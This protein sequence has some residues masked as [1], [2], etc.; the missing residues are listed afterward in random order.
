MV[1]K[2]VNQSELDRSSVA[3]SLRA[4]A[5]EFESGED[6]HVRVGNK[7]IRLQPPETVSYE[8]SV[9]E[10]SSILRSSR[11]TITLTVDWKTQ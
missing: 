10:T 3:E 2:T 4:L 5:D 11:E 9:H 8:V 6:V 7:S 1:E